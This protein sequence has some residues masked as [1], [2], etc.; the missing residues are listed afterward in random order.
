[1]DRV[2]YLNAMRYFVRVVELGS[3]S[4]AA[5]ETAV[6]TSTISRAVG[7]LEADLGIA[8]LNRSTRRLHPTEAGF[9]F[10]GRACRILGNF[11]AACQQVSCLSSRAQGVLKIHVPCTFGCRH[12]IPLLPEFY[13]RYPD[14]KLD[15]RLTDAPV[16][17]IGSGIDLAIFFGRLPDSALIAKKLAMHGWILC[18]SP[19]YLTGHQ[20]LE[21][22][23]DLCRHSCLLAGAENWSFARAD[24]QVEVQ[25]SGP[26]QADAREALFAGVRCDLG[27]ALLPTWLIADDLDSGR[28]LRVL[29]DWEPRLP[30]DEGT[31]WGA[32]APKKAVPRKLRV[33]I[34]FM[35]QR[36]R[37]RISGTRPRQG[38]AEFS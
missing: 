31:I 18:A 5:Q 9:D 17:I 34:D 33:F 32:Y 36:L 1:M 29:A 2:D 8:L 25:V 21:H 11:D 7:G 23:Q 12:V 19:A 30:A 15:V 37:Q 20:P 3:L 10:Y 16:D 35:E 22:P 24:E 4:R 28:L 14:V 6:K 13:A 38:K 27:I 26:L